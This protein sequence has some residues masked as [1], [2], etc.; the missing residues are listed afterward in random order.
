ME[1]LKRLRKS[2]LKAAEDESSKKEHKRLVPSQV[3]AK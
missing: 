1:D 2:F 3:L